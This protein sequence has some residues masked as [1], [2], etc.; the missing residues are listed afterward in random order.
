MIENFRLR[1]FRTVAE[2]MNFREAAEA[3]YLT[4]PAVTLQIKTLEQEL[5]TQLFDRGGS[6]ITLTDAGRTLLK[7]SKKMAAIAAAAERELARLKGEE[8]GA[9]RIGASTTIAQY[10][11]PKLA[12]DFARMHPQVSFSVVSANTEKIADLM[13]RGEIPLGLVEGPVLRRG[14]RS[15]PFLTD[16]IVAILPARHEWAGQILTI[17]QVAAE[18]LIF[19]E[20][21]SGTRR[22]VEAALE[23]AGV[24]TKK[25]RVAMELDSTEAIKAAVEE[26][27]G[28][29]FVSTR[30]IRKELKLG[31]L[32]EADVKD[33]IIRRDFSVVSKRGPELDGLAAGFLQ[34]LRAIFTRTAVKHT[35]H[36]R[37]TR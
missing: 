6:R 16:E 26:G 19:R 10:L 20:R 15:E 18:P 23:K 24:V 14:I 34:Y 17:A 30:A 21:G 12:G 29:G 32:R 36:D 4:Q 2:K 25:L 35:R 8:Q 5:N 33:L 22:V 7:H 27:L 3:L 13:L 28:V 37:A 31:T 11:L 1:V 9:L